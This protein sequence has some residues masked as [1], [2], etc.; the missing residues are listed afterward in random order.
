M[1]SGTHLYEQRISM[2]QKQ[3]VLNTLENTDMK[4]P[5]PDPAIDPV[6]EPNIL[7]A[8]PKKNLTQNASL[9]QNTL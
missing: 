3:F 9:I 1:T 5:D 4:D 8:F 7:K 6:S 2:E